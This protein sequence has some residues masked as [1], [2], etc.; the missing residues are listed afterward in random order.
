MNG[1][2]RS[3]LPP[4]R[5]CLCR[6]NRA[7]TALTCGASWCQK[8]VFPFYRKHNLYVLS[9]LENVRTCVERKIPLY[10][11][12][13]GAEKTKAHLG[14]TLIPSFILFKHRHPA[15]DRFLMAWPALSEKILSRL[16]FWPA[17]SPAA[18]GVLTRDR[19]EPTH[20]RR[21][22]PTAQ[23]NDRKRGERYQL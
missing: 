11:A 16:G 22:D 3:L 10:L 8:R 18:S 20:V 12:G 2:S 17:A 1:S 23:A 4:P 7:S 19:Q 9:W 14:A 15:I 13:P 6:K 21:P 5:F